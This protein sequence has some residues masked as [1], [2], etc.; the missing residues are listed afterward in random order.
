MNKPINDF[1]DL[2]IWQ[3]AISFA[4]AVYILT[5]RFPPDEK[6]GMTS[7][8][9]RAAVSV[10]SN[11][12]EG[13]ARQRKEF[14]YFLSIARGSLAETESLLFLAVELGYLLLN[15]TTSARNLAQEIRRMAS[16][17]SRVIDSQR[18]QA[19]LTPGP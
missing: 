5:K 16:K 13:Y 8:I 6:F 4:K 2:I 17:L 15:D 19:V 7:Q 12:A 3:K 10:S 11:I 14:S 1:R 18:G 9:R